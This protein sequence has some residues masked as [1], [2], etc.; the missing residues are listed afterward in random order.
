VV[1]TCF[2][3]KIHPAGYMESEEKLY[4]K[5]LVKL[6]KQYNNKYLEISEE[7]SFGF[8]LKGFG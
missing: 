1:E 3:V 5:Q 7:I 8:Q 6:G 2:T 4:F